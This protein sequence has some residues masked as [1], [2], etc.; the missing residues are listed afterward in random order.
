MKRL[1]EKLHRHQPARI[2]VVKPSSLGDVVD[3]MP[4]LGSSH[5]LA[6]FTRHVGRSPSVS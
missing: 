2:C 6:E 5:V 3:A 1:D 4:I